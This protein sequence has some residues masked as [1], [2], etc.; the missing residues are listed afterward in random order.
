ML[1]AIGA[2]G[3]PNINGRFFRI[4][5]PPGLRPTLESGGA[6]GRLGIKIEFLGKGVF[7]ALPGPL[8]AQKIE[9][10]KVVA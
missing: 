2:A 9:N 10:K 4:V 5:R 1:T 7:F 3:L 6:G 8:K